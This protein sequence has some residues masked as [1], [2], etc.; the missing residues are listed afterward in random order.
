MDRGRRK[1]IQSAAALS[2]GLIA[3]GRA[4][5]AQQEQQMQMPPGMKMDHGKWTT[6]R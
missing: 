2:A 6:A 3:A 4:A 5:S 1:F